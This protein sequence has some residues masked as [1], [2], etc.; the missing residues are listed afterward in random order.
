MKKKFLG[1][2]SI[3]ILLSTAATTVLAAPKDL[4]SK[5]KDPFQARC[6]SI[7]V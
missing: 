3:L 5:D 4:N 7:R 1:V 6:R 2:I